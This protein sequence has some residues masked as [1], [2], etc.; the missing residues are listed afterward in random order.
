M[1]GFKPA[2]KKEFYDIINDLDICV[3]SNI[4]EYPHKHF[5][6]KFSYRNGE[7]FGIS[8]RSL[9]TDHDDYGVNYYH[10]KE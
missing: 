3:N 10:I 5:Y 9:E 4:K 8:I 1:D 6:T 2:T 7:L